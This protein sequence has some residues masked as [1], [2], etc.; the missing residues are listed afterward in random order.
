MLLALQVESFLCLSVVGFVRLAAK[1]GAALVPVLAMGE[2][3]T[4]RNFVDLP[5][6]QV[7]L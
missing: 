7:N 6:V 3:N 2:L 5:A 1:H 4:L